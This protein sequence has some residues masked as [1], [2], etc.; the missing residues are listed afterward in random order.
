MD[1]DITYVCECAYCGLDGTDSDPGDCDEKWE[2]IAN[3]HAVWCE[4]V[5]TRAH[6]VELPDA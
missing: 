4:W 6:R 5:L 2:E 3:Q 1:C